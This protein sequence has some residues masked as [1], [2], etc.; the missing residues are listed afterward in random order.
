MNERAATVQAKPS[1]SDAS[2][3]GGLL[4][5]KCVCGNQTVSGGECESC[6]H[7][8]LQRKSLDGSSIDVIPASVH[9]VLRGS[10][11]P[12][13]SRTRAAMETGF[14]QDFSGV[15]IHVDGAAAQ[16]ARAVDALAYTVGR[17]VVFASGQYEPNTS[18]GRRLIAH[19]LAHVVQQQALHA[20]PAGISAPD[21]AM[22]READ[23][24]ADHVTSG[25]PSPP[26]PR[27]YTP[28][29]AREVDTRSMP[30]KDDGVDKVH[31]IVTPGKCAL[32]PQSRAAT[33]GDIGSSSAFLQ[34]DL[35]RGSVAGQL[36]GELDYGSALQQAGQAV[37]KLLS[38][39]TSGQSSQQ[40]LSTFSN[41]LK[42]LKPG[43]HVKL[44]LLAS[45]VFRLDI[46]GMGGASV[47]G[48]ASGKATTRAEFDTGPVKLSVEGSVSG[49]TQ[50]QTRYEITG[51]ITFGG[52]RQRAPDCRACEC[53]DTK[54]QFLCN[55]VPGKGDTP[56]AKPV[57][58]QP[59]YIPYFFDYADI[60]PN[61]RL[62]HMNETNLY[63]AVNL[64]N[65]NYTIARIEGSASPEGPAQGKRGP[66][67]N[68]TRLAEA[69][70]IE[71]KKRLDAVI[72][73]AIQEPMR[74]RTDQLRRALGAGYPVVGRGE[75]FGADARSEVADP[76]L[77]PHLQHVLAPPA[78]GQPDP[79]A[80]EHVT[81]A[82]LSA[83][84]SA[85][86]QADVEAF[87]SGKRG[88]KKLSDADRLEAIYQPLR[89]ALFVFDPPPEPP[90]NLRLGQKGIE[91]VIGKPIDCNDAHRALFA[92]VPIAKPFEGEC[93]GP[94]KQADKP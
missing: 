9:K 10:G 46:T 12:L 1:S 8:R 93:S 92:G 28:L 41:D 25:F 51:N 3:I 39:S 78:E 48:G 37:G 85:E 44:N 30:A 76:A 22:E 33:S 45:D 23:R 66:F 6:A 50:D 26:L 94:G 5:R 81:G 17:N 35:C 86:T 65:A 40:A 87:R 55:H 7:M 88:D 89:R 57:R 14:G 63:E 73:R 75:L 24:A 16:S 60:T 53:S 67:T 59:R 84:V 18:P 36:R 34:I 52:T 27:A 61:P 64:L 80:Q 72:Q 11:V 20:V 42:Q 56:P 79:L 47:A 77:M 70:A 54:L 31:R 58:P 29:I 83:D 49:G 4:Q 74:M 38:N 68:N 91:N 71:G 21:S 2:S 32:A 13:E 19:E 62:T 69:R 82:G 90:A 43:A 15:R